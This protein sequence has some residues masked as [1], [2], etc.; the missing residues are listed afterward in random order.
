[1]P[2]KVPKVVIGGGSEKA[3]TQK[4]KILTEAGLPEY[5]RKVRN[6][7]NPYQVI[8]TVKAIRKK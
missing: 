7:T 8:K 3:M 2:K 6:Y 1:V 4:R 5:A